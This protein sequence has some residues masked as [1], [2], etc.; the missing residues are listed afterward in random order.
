MPGM[1]LGV[2]VSFSS[3]AGRFGNAGQTDY[4]AAN[5]LLCK[6]TSSLPHWRPGTRGIAVDWT[7]WGGLGMAT[8]G[9][10]PQLMALAGI[11]VL[12]PECGVPT[13][14]RELIAG[15]FSGEVVVAGQLGTLL[16]EPAET[17]GLEP[18]RAAASA[19]ERRLLMVGQVSAA[20]LTSGLAVETTLDPAVQPFLHD[21]ALDGTPLLPG[22]MGLE[23]FAQEASLFAPGRQVDAIVNVRFDQ[24]FKF[25]HGQPRT[26][27][28]SA[29]LNPLPDGGLLAHAALDSRTQPAKPGLPVQEKRH[30]VG[31]VRLS[32]RPPVPPAAIA[33]PAFTGVRLAREDLYQVFFHGPA[34]QVLQEAY[35]S[36]EGAVGVMAADLP[37]DTAPADA[38]LLMAPRLIELCFQTAGAWELQTTGRLALP[39]SLGTVSAY[40][41]PAAG[42]KS[43]LL[44]LV[45]TRD[46]GQSF[47]A[48]VLDEAGNVYVQLEAYRTLPLPRGL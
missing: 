1:P 19:A 42:P 46:H 11:E 47:D 22:V 36:A 2:V 43:R 16:H 35:V 4:S 24:P 9:S 18:L 45:Q 26:L 30:F 23:A 29:A 27:R 5:D 20:R 44:A 31:Q 38:P 15:G 37:P 39:R 8:R 34:Y 41:Q 7:A 48:W 3:V 17:G 21:H 14:R 10:I 33:V 40:P 6:L 13:V 28:L 25:Y 12:P 32:R